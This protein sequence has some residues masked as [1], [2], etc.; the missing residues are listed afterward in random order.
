MWYEKYIYLLLYLADK[1]GSYGLTLSQEGN[2]PQGWAL[3]DVS[4]DSF[5][6]YQDLSEY[7]GLK[8]IE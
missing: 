8:N 1:G 3:Q 2:K 6:Y 4:N 7:V 5:V